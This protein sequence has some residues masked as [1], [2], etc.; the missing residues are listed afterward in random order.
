MREI[1]LPP[2]CNR[3]LFDSDDY[4][5][6]KALDNTHELYKQS[7]FLL[8]HINRLYKFI[9]EQ[10]YEY[11]EKPQGWIKKINKKK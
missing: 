3:D 6:E 10:G 9:E 2:Y 4:D 5:A 11:N 8:E 1:K 7:I